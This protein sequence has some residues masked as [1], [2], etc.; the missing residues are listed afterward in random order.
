MEFPKQP[1]ELKFRNFYHVIVCAVLLVLVLTIRWRI[2]FDFCFLITDCD[3]LLL[4]DAANDMHKGIFHEP[5]F[6]GQSYNPLVE[7]LF[8]QPFIFLGMPLRYALPLV[9]WIFGL[10]PYLL[11][12]W[13]FLKQKKYLTLA[14]TFAYMLWLPIEFHA[15]DSMP[16]G[17]VPACAFASIGIY[18]AMF[19]D[20]SSRFFWFGFM[21]LV[22]ITISQN[23]VFLIVPVGIYLWLVHIKDLK[24]YLHVIAGLIVALP[25]PVY[26]YWFY[27]THPANI[28]HLIEYTFG[29]DTFTDT[30]SEIQVYFNFLTPD[31]KNK[32]IVVTL[33]YILFAIVC[34][35]KKNIKAGIAI[36]CG[37]MILYF[38]FWF[39]K[40]ED[41][42]DSLF[43]S[44]VR[45]FLGVPLVVI[46]FSYWTESSFKIKSYRGWQFSILSFL[47]V[48][49]IICSS[50]RN[51]YFK[52]KLYRPSSDTDV[53]SGKRVDSLIDYCNHL[54]V[55]CT[56][57]HT[58][59]VILE[60]LQVGADYMCPA[61]NYP[62]KILRPSYERRTW[63]MKQ[64]DTTIRT[65]FIYFPLYPDSLLMALPVNLD[66]KSTKDP[67][68]FLI[69]THGRGVF[70]IL[71]DMK[72]VVR[73]H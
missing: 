14:F 20:K 31:A 25:L 51:R 45:I 5:C 38:S 3:Q 39:D 30:L 15:I 9:S 7:P 13:A 17:Y 8:A 64:E 61:L 18:L 47:L 27:H 33:G 52:A 12:S 48:I 6:Y 66:I 72:V 69:N 11:F 60:N 71:K 40:V 26:I 46:I 59:L 43:F 56:E 70:D 67:T 23:C 34:F 4:W 10:F 19:T 32:L 63:D 16:R 1:G 28:V 21:S 44:S 35:A 2:L 65:G 55:L 58:N 37:L 73:P 54:K 24:F 22:A 42:T 41:G 50:E 57:N 36:L 68:G 53:V 49:G 29:F 62:F